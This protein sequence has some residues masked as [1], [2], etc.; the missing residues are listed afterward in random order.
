MKLCQVKGPQ[1][2][3][4][5]IQIVKPA[6]VVATT[7]KMRFVGTWISCVPCGRC[8]VTGLTATLRASGKGKR[9]AQP[10]GW[11]SSVRSGFRVRAVRVESD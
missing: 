7:H 3:L 1:L 6:L 11:L 8:I 9:S 5:L 10:E 2:T 4:T